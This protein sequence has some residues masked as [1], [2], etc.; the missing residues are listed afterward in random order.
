VTSPSLISPLLPLAIVLFWLSVVLMERSRPD[1]LVLVLFAA[2]AG[3]SWLALP[4]SALTGGNLVGSV[5]LA[6]LTTVLLPLAWLRDPKPVFQWLTPV[7]LIQ[8]G[9]CLYQAVFGLPGTHRV[10]GFAE[11]QNAGAGFLLLGCIYLLN[12]HHRAKWLILP[13]VMAMPFTGSR[14]AALVAAVVVLAIF[15]AHLVK[16]QYIAVG[17][18]AAL[19]LVTIL[20]WDSIWDAYM[21]SHYTGN[22]WVD[23]VARL[24]PRDGVSLSLV[25]LGF[26]DSGLHNVPWRMMH[27]TGILSGLAWG[28]ATLYGLWRRPRHHYAWWLLLTIALLSMMDYYTWVGPLGWVWWPLVSTTRPRRARLCLRE[29]VSEYDVSGTARS[30]ASSNSANFRFWSNFRKSSAVRNWPGSWSS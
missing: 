17:M 6:I 14:W 25:P 3:S 10:L 8:A 4:I 13:M 23:G 19:G 21:L 20:G 12:G 18:A 29:T 26:W 22:P 11:N 1:R 15:A 30:P 2:I 28:G 24:T 9:I 16:W 27:E 7:W 5:W